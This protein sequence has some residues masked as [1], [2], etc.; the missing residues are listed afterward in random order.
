MKCRKAEKMISRELD[1]RLSLA[2]KKLLDEHLKLCPACSEAKKEYSRIV[3]VL[4]EEKLP[5]PAPGYLNR[6][7]T[8][9]EEKPLPFFSTSLIWQRWAL[10]AL[11]LA[12]ILIFI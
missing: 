2:E 11:P 5:Q 8:R 6:L 9:I 1:S 7:L 4:R 10:K 3:R 12:L